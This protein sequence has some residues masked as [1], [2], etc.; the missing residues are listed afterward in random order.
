MDRVSARSG[1]H[2]AHFALLPHSPRIFVC[3]SPFRIQTMKSGFSR[4]SPSSQRT[5]FKRLAMGALSAVLILLATPGA[6][7][8]TITVTN[9]SDSDPGSLRDAITAANLNADADTI[10]FDT[11]VTGTINLQSA[12]PV[13]STEMTIQGPGATVL[14]VRRDT[15][16]DYRIFTIASGQTVIISGLTISNGSPTGGFPAGEGGGIFND[17]TLTLQD[18]IVTGNSAVSGT[19]DGGGIYNTFNGTLTLE[20]STVSGNTA[21]GIG[22]AIVTSGPLTVTN[23]T[24]SGNSCGNSGGAIYNDGATLIVTNSTL[25]GNNAGNNGGG[26][27]HDSGSATLTNVTITNNRADNDNNGSG[28]GGGIFHGGD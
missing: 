1:N 7:A 2:P 28:T 21:S 27:I 15:G 10:V 11:G 12:L 26:V 14:T 4:I 3:H 18:S 17:G 22:G 6:G 20:H 25:S 9:A 19:N 5:K 16:G 8:A 13:L 24:L 23:S